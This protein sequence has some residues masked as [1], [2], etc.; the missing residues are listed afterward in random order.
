MVI[1]ASQHQHRDQHKQAREACHDD[2]D[3]YALS[4]IHDPL[5]S[6]ALRMMAGAERRRIR[7]GEEKT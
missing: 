7:P 6:G 4:P 1:F 5:H 2:P 3:Q